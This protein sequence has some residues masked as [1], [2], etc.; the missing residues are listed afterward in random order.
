VRKIKDKKIKASLVPKSQSVSPEWFYVI[1]LL[2]LLIFLHFC[3]LGVND[4]K[5]SDILSQEISTDHNEHLVHIIFTLNLYLHLMRFVLA[6][7]MAIRYFSVFT[8]TR[9]VCQGLF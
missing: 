7:F 5:K 2:P 9:R 8:D 4:N 6:Y 3:F 1:V